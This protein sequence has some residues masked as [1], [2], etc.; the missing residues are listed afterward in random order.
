MGLV[1]DRK[2]M[3]MNELIGQMGVMG[4]Q[5]PSMDQTTR[6]S[7]SVATAGNWDGRYA[8]FANDEFQRYYGNIQSVYTSIKG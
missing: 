4:A 5:D 8:R 1:T 2:G 7:M 6:T 3:G